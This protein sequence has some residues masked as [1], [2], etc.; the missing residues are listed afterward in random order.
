MPWP[1]YFTPRMQSLADDIEEEERKIQELQAIQRPQRPPW[2]QKPLERYAQ[3]QAPL[4]QAG[5]KAATAMG[6]PFEYLRE[7]YSRPAAAGLT[8]PGVS[9]LK[10]E[11]PGAQIFRQDIGERIRQMQQMSTMG[12][13][14]QYMPGGIM[15]PYWMFLPGTKGREAYEEWEAPKYLRGGIETAVEMPL[16]MGMGTAAGAR[17]GL[18]GKAAKGGRLAKPAGIAAKALKPVAAAEA[19]PGKAIGGITGKLAAR[20]AAKPLPGEKAIVRLTELIKAYKPIKRV[21]GKMKHEEWVKRVARAQREITKGKGTP[22]AYNRAMKRLAGKIPTPEAITLKQQLTNREYVSLVKRIAAVG[23]PTFKQIRTKKA[24]DKL[25]LATEIPTEGELILLEKTYGT[26][27]IKAVLKNRQGWGTIALDVLNSPRAVLASFD[28]SFPLRQGIF[29]FLRHPIAGFK[30]LPKMVRAAFSDKYCTQIDDA[31]R[32]MPHFEKGQ[33]M[34]LYMAPLPTQKAPGLAARAEPFMARGITK[35]KWNPIRMSE[36]AFITM[37]NWQRQSSWNAFCNKWAGKGLTQGDYQSMA[38][39]INLST[40]RGSFGKYNQ[41]APVL[42]TF[43]FSP[44]YLLS[45]LQ[46]PAM[47]FSKSPVVRKEAWIRLMEFIGTG[48]GILAMLKQS[49]VADVETNPRSTD[50]AKIKIGNTRLDIWSGY[51]QYARFAVQMAT[52]ERKKQSGEITD[53]SR[54]LLLDY[55][56]RTKEAPFIGFM[57]DLMRGSGYRGEQI[58]FTTKSAR[59]QAYNRLMP[60]WLQDVKDAWDDQGLYGSLIVSPGI[61]GVGAMTYEQERQG[62][63]GP[64]GFKGGGFKSPFK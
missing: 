47:L 43:I 2:W 6:V 5:A 3:M 61:L 20:R 59:E 27:F 13:A 35:G 57:E 18:L 40:G 25:L 29:E 58:E 17:M 50:F 22:E 21:A 8:M 4:W 32:K 63:L 12:K 62:P 51:Q 28:F 23:E 33:N 31:L 46:L 42:S 41:L 37:G 36:R 9:M 55:F 45:R 64:G 60:M 24:L 10:P 54:Y 34:K 53:V 15:S 49:G 52:G 16:W 38:H 14:R 30:G 7:Y 1:R 11:D 39:L 44:R 26:E 48:F 56:K 19:L